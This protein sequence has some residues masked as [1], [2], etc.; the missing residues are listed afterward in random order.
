[1]REVA[2]RSRD[3]GREND[4]IQQIEYPSCKK[5]EEKYEPLGKKIDGGEHYTKK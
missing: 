1:M 3:G 5:F 2:R 4:R